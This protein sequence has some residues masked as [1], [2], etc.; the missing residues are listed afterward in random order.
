MSLVDKHDLGRETTEGWHQVDKESHPARIPGNRQPIL[1]I[2][3]Y[4]ADITGYPADIIGYP[5]NIP[6]YPV[7]ITGYPLDL[8]GHPH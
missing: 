5:A 1:D 8:V 4:S 6:G 2:V 7:D 3:G